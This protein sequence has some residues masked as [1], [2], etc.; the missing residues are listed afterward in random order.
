MTTQVHLTVEGIDIG[1]PTTRAAIEGSDL[2]DLAWTSN[3]GL[4]TVTCFVEHGQHPVADALDWARCITKTTG[5]RVPRAFDE[6]VATA[7]IAARC[8]VTTEAVRL[9]TS[10]RRRTGSPFPLPRQQVA[11]GQARTMRLY[12]W[13]DVVAWVRQ[14]LGVDPEDGDGFLSDRQ[15]ADLDND[16]AVAYFEDE[17]RTS[18]YEAFAAPTGRVAV[19]NVAGPRTV[20]T[21]VQ[22]G[23]Q[24]SAKAGEA[25]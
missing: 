19:D 16:L 14:T 25:A 17:W 5:G 15:L 8:D 2:V 6:L 4:L 24:Q 11:I 12:A 9:W 23:T 1:S 20:L 7:E 18:A 22:A 13:R 3:L 10:G 21:A